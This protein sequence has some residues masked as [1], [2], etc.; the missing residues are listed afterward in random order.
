MGQQF[1]NVASPQTQQQVDVEFEP[2][3]SIGMAPQIAPERTDEILE[4]DAAVKLPP[5]AATLEIAES[6][7]VQG[8]P[9]PAIDSDSASDQDG[10]VGV[11]IGAQNNQ[12]AV[13]PES[14]TIVQSQDVEV[15]HPE[16]PTSQPAGNADPDQAQ[17]QALDR[18][19]SLEQ[20]LRLLPFYID[21]LEDGSLEVDLGD[22]VTFAFDSAELRPSSITTLDKIAGA[23]KPYSDISLR[24]VGHTDGAGPEIYNLAL[25]EQRAAAVAKYL[26]KLRGD[27]GDWVQT[28][29]RGESEPVEPGNR[30]RNRRIVLYITPVHQS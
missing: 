7:P 17:N 30:G 18:F 23:L 8:L 19:S 29:G 20:A 15:V 21:R 6:L 1:E 12:H 13:D 28:E 10:L 2:G 14:K 25:S 5:S 27:E 11:N 3:D 9:E 16:L 22:T 4:K 24:V 26:R